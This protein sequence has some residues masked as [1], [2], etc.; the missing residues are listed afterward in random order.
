VRIGQLQRRGQIPNRHNRGIRLAVT[1]CGTVLLLAAAS[2]SGNR[3]NSARHANKTSHPHAPR[4][5]PGIAPSSAGYVGSKV[6]AQCHAPIASKY[7][8]T[9][10]GRSM[11]EIT[12]TL[13]GKIP[14]AA[15]VIDD[16]LHRH[17]DVRAEDGRLLQSEYEIGEDGNEVF[18]ETH[19]VDWIIGS[20]ANGFGALTKRG[21][22]LFEAPLSFYSKTQAWALSPGYEFGDYGFNRPILPGCIACHSGRPQAVL[23]G[24]G[25]FL[26]PP[27]RELAI[28]CENCHG[29]GE[30]HV[31]EMREGD[32]GDE[33]GTHSIVNP[34]KLEPWLADNIC[35]SCHQTGDAIVLK[36]GKDYRDFRPGTPLDDTLAI[37]MVPPRRDSPQ[38]D[39]L[40]HY[41]SM[42]LSKCYRSSGGRLSCIGCH[43][44]H[45]EPANQ[46]APAYY[47]QKCLSCHTEK[48][49]ALPFAIR[50]RKT[51]P[52]D[53]VGCHMPKRNVQVIAHAVLTNHRIVAQAEE[54]YPDAA[55]HMTTPQM[56]D[57]VHLSAIPTKRDD[58]V[59]PM[60]RLQAY[61]QLMIPNP[62][63][64]GRYFALAKQL[65][66]AN[67]NNVDVLEAL[68]ALSIERKNDEEAIRYL[69]SAVK[70]DAT[71]PQTY[72]QLAS[73]LVQ[74]GRYQEAVD[75]LERGIKQLP[76]DA[77]LYR[78]LG[79]TYLSLHRN[80]DATALLQQA[81]QN[82]PQDAVLRK[83][84]KD[85]EGTVPSR[86]AP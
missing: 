42:T 74:L 58:P 13:L 11:S 25:K 60:I 9:D 52:D 21:E 20:G 38:T 22:F 10:M 7:S 64:R 76:Y 27:F 69:D 26:D 14:T 50:Q 45:V 23:G 83:L 62:D 70:H 46:D 51:P 43:D 86:N 35:M 40:E 78:L 49:C 61:G 19:P 33:R 1:L 55:F 30:A 2:F 4:A 39:L 28:G 54:P 81:V 84:L 5:F 57:L 6:C 71:S 59:S 16:R 47:R 24:N 12:P 31:R 15:S 65:E 36:A 48:S 73:L 53:C 75:V 41:F 63:Y 80:S 44:P 77:M 67:S 18:R 82:F 79:P 37:F 66:A 3:D 85:S 29:P 34:A 72:E 56:P 32:S 8:R 17:F 68:A